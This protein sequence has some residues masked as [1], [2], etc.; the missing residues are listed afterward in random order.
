ML[1]VTELLKMST[2][3]AYNTI[4]E[5][6]TRIPLVVSDMEARVAAKEL[7]PGG[8]SSDKK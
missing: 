1:E 5:E 2:S 8:R 6:T 3:P 7:N 4:L